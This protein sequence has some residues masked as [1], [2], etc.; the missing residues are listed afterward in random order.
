MHQKKT[1]TQFNKRFAKGSKTESMA[2]AKKESDK[3]EAAA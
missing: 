3:D 2:V 1:R